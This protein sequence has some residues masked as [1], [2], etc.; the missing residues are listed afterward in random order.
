[1]ASEA[2]RIRHRPGGTEAVPVGM[3]LSRTVPSAWPRLIRV[4]VP[5]ATC[6]TIPT[7]APSADPGVVVAS[8][9]A[10][11]AD[12]ASTEAAAAHG[13]VALRLCGWKV[14]SGALTGASS[15]GR[16]HVITAVC[17]TTGSSG[18][19]TESSA[20]SRPSTAAT[21]R[22]RRCARSPPRWWW[23][24]WWWPGGWWPGCSV[25]SSP[26][27]D[28]QREVP[29]SPEGSTRGRLVQW[30]QRAMHPSRAVIPWFPSRDSLV[31]RDSLV[32]STGR[33][34]P[35]GPGAAVAA[36]A[37]R[38]AGRVWC[39]GSTARTGAPRASR[40]GASPAG[41]AGSRGCGRCSTA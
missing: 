36:T 22:S 20:P 28:G 8:S 31:R 19:A 11:C 32:L 38:P 35:P 4:S 1:M 27:P 5:P 40:S 24:R 30:D 6:S 25:A 18:T 15:P 13:I 17:W 26:A 3:L 21:A 14:T 39:P 2:T 33:S 16:G 10:G 12:R 37:E 23:P 9:A 34:A 41:T 7:A 29:K